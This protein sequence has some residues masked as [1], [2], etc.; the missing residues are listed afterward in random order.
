MNGEQR[1]GEAEA[2][3]RY[4]VCGNLI[5]AGRRIARLLLPPQAGWQ[6]PSRLSTPHRPPVLNGITV[7]GRLERL[8][9]GGWVGQGGG[10]DV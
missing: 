10:S 4:V 8:E 6:R 7:A 9:E 1:G 5:V 3:I 2:K